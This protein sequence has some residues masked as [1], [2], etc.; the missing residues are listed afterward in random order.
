MKLNEITAGWLCFKVCWTS[1]LLTS[2]YCCPC[3]VY[4]TRYLA[5]RI[6]DYLLGTATLP[7][8]ERTPSCLDSSPKTLNWILSVDRNRGTVAGPGEGRFQW[9][10]VNRARLV[11]RLSPTHVDLVC[12]LSFLFRAQNNKQFIGIIYDQIVTKVHG[13]HAVMFNASFSNFNCIAHYV[14]KF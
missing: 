8:N 6:Q 4:N 13:L 7:Q 2:E 5:R 14:W 3:P 12:I 1:W 11:P 10:R 9:L